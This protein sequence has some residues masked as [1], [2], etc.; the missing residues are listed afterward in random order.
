MADLCWQVLKVLLGWLTS[1]SLQWMR[2]SIQIL[3]RDF[4]IRETCVVDAASG[5]W[6][7]NVTSE[8]ESKYQPQ[9]N[10][11]EHKH[12]YVVIAIQ[13]GRAI[14]VND[15]RALKNCGADKRRQD[16]KRTGRRA[17]TGDFAW[18]SVFPDPV[19]EE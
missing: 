3:K 1:L 4:K 6:S 18:P 10:Q 13:C 11:C 17:G 15:A 5:R 12:T 7:S 8:T 9:M 2:T 14:P 16:Y 19:E